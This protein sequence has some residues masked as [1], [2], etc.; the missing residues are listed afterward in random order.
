[1]E[2]SVDVLSESEKIKSIDELD[3]KKYGIIVTDGYR[4]GV[5]LPD[6]DG[7]DSV[8]QQISIARR[9]AGIDPDEE[10]TI[11]RFEVVRHV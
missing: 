7:V 11:E 3:V 5:L 10:I 6:L 9:K 8:D 4:Q 1:L 2:I